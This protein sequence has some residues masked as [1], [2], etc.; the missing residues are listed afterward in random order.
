[1]G[2]GLGSEGRNEEK[3]K[4]FH[5]PISRCRVPAPAEDRKH[6]NIE[7]QDGSHCSLK[8]SIS[9]HQVTHR[10]KL[11]FQVLDEPTA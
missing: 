3:G 5:W 9:R 4:R 10:Q 6:F 1:M 7:T 8:L 11:V 2:V